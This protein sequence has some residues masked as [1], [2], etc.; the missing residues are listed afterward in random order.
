[1]GA[2]TATN[3]HNRGGKSDNSVNLRESNVDGGH[4]GMADCNRWGDKTETG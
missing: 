4:T 2:V 3:G 1:M